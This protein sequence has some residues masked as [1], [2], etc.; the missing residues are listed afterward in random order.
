MDETAARPTSGQR[1][2]IES[3]LTVCMLA[4]GSKGNAI[5]VSD[6]TTSI[7]LDAGLSGVEI[8]RRLNTLGLKAEHLDAILV[9]HEHSDHI[10]GVGI[11][12][13][14]YHLP[15]YLTKETEKA[16]HCIVG[17]LEETKHFQCGEPLNINTLSVRPF[18][19]CHDA[20]DPAG[21]T[22]SHQGIKLGVATD[23]GVATS[24][25]KTHL[26]GCTALILE[27]N[28]DPAMLVNGPYPWP[29]KQRVKGRTGHLSNS[30]SRELLK[31]LLH[32]GLSHVI[33][34]HLSETNNTMEKAISE[35]GLALQTCGKTILT[36]ATQDK[37]SEVFCFNGFK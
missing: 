33:L 21:F 28:H 30:D 5:Y 4:S 12:S 11:L 18:S 6:G 32:D 29:L 31:E 10:K 9:S 27:A 14:R 25:V 19:I 3:P 16:A 26:K 34:A 24:L 20:A 37:C 15:V 7:L 22:F 17:R 1:Q 35:V 13:R 23:L 8:E 2:T 36:G